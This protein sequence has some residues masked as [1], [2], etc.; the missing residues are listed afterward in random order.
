MLRELALPGG[1][2]ASSQDADTDGVEG[3]TYTWTEDEGVA[4]SCSQPFEHGRSIIRGELDA[5]AARAAARGAS[6]APA[7]GARRQ[8]DRRLERA[9]A[10][11]ARRGRASSAECHRAASRGEARRVPARASSPRQTVGSSGPGATGAHRSPAYLEDY[12][13][14][15]HGLIELHVATGDL[16]WLEEANRLARLAVELFADEQRGGFFMTAHD[17]EQLVA[18]KKDLDDNPVPSG[19]SMLAHVLLRLC[20]DLRRRRAR[21]ARRSACCGSCTARSTRA[22]SAFGW[23]LCALDL[24]LSPPRELAI[25]GAPDDELARAALAPFEPNAS[26]PSGRR[27]RSAAR[28]KGAGRRQADA[29][30]LRALRLPRP[31]HRVDELG[32]WRR[33]VAPAS[34][35]RT[36]V[37][38]IVRKR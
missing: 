29:L 18:R 38:T 31:G 26:S 15:A 10:R 7:A 12:A 2:F 9:R 1:G 36:R 3:L 5:R 13:D 11:G 27:R 19:N 33:H 34:A 37:G 32:R 22:P 25:I 35:P 17:A 16:R 21:A 4:A 6:A 23:A 8:G 30:R 20:A 24:Y 28:R 14:V